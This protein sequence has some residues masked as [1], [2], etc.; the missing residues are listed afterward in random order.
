MKWKT[1]IV[2]LFIIL[3]IMAPPSLPLVNGHEARIGALDVCRSAAPA[4]SSQ[5][6]MPCVN[7]CPYPLP[8]EG[9]EIGEIPAPPFKP[10]LIAF[11]DEHPPKV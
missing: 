8:M 2:L 9:G 5:G 1:V 11:Q 4:M 3:G 6:D 7:G 10:L